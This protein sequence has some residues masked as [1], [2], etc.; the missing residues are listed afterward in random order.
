MS[1]QDLLA[2]LALD[3]EKPNLRI[4]VAKWQVLFGLWFAMLVA[5]SLL[6]LGVSGGLHASDVVS[7]RL[8]G[9]GLGFIQGFTL[10]GMID[11]AWRYFLAWRCR[12]VDLPSRRLAR[13]IEINDQRL[14]L[15]LAGALALAFAGG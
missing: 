12:R 14:L 7:A 3:P 9:W 10:V 8:I 2:A 11:S 1:G 13:L 5:A 4:A 6:W 15:Q